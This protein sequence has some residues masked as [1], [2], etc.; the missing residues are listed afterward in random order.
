MRK[1]TNAVSATD[2]LWLACQPQIW[3]LHHSRPCVNNA[4]V[5]VHMEQFHRLDETKLQT[6]W[7]LQSRFVV[8]SIAHE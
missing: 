1:E 5:N 8:A 3:Q 7:V 2:S 4:K 6:A